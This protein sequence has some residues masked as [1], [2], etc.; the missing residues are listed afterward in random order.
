MKYQG[1]LIKIGGS[2]SDRVFLAKKKL[3]FWLTLQD[4]LE[5]LILNLQNIYYL[6]NSLYNLISFNLFNDSGIFYDN[7]NET[8]PSQIKA[9]PGPGTMLEK[10]LPLKASKLIQ[11]DHKPTLDQ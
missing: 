1:L 3:Q 9:N 11:W 6:S 7:K 10:Y 8:V 4:E 5:S 2:T